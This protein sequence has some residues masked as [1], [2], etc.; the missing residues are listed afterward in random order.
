L[1]ASTSIEAVNIQLPVIGMQVPAVWKNAYR[2]RKRRGGALAHDGR[3]VQ[4]LAVVAPHEIADFLKLAFARVG[5][6]IVR[7]APTWVRLALFSS[8]RHLK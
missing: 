8:A 7:G 2:I 5:Q 3:A 1:S 4:C 6:R